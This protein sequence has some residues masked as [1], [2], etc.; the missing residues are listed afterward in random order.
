MNSIIE[1]EYSYLG[2]F[3]DGE[4]HIGIK[5]EAP[6]GRA[7][8]PTYTERA[9]VAGTN[10]LSIEV[11]NQYWPG[12]FYYH[13]PGKSSKAGCWSWEVTGKKARDFLEII[14][15]YL[16]VKR[17]DA[18]IVLALGKNKAKTHGGKISNEDRKLRDDLYQVLK[19]KRRLLWSK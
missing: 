8:L 17:L 14:K 7:I 16:F 15:P 6:R 11:F 4:G 1:K 18:D 3:M 5:K 9:S 10:K 19:A 12:H 2:G 13:K